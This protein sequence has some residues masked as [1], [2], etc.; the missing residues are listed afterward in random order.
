MAKRTSN[1]EMKPQIDWVKLPKSV[2]IIGLGGRH[3]VQGKEYI[4]SKETAQIL[5]DKGVATLK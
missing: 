3:L 4:V 2:T 5:I 1:K